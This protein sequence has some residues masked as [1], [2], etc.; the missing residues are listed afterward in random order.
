MPT[1]KTEV[2]ELSVA[3]GI[4]GVKPINPVLS[5]E[6]IPTKFE[7]TLPYDKYIKYCEGVTYMDKAQNM[8]AIPPGATIREH[9]VLRGITQEDFARDLGVSE[10]YISQL[11]EG[12]VELTP[13]IALRLIVHRGYGNRC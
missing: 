12:N 10:E 3:F 8:V 11:L 13:D 1:L 4:L 7:N 9:L 5:E 2:S 6:E